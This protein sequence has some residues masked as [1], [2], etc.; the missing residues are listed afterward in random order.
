[1]N[2]RV[3][4]EAFSKSPPLPDVMD[5]EL[6]QRIQHPTAK[7][8]RALADCL[9]G[10]ALYEELVRAVHREVAPVRRGASSGAPEGKRHSVL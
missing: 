7:T 10:P 9:D 3:S 2:A 6:G 4:G 1:M 5:L 8:L